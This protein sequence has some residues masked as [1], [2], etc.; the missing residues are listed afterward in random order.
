[1]AIR[2]DS[3]EQFLLLALFSLPSL[4]LNSGIIHRVGVGVKSNLH[5]RRQQYL[6]VKITHGIP[7][8]K[9]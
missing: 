2:V 7:Q 6:F 5:R 1:M 8:Y 9:Y 4:T 3:V